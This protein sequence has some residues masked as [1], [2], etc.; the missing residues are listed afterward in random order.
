VRENACSNCKLYGTKCE[1]PD[2]LLIDDLLEPLARSTR[3]LSH[4]KDR[5]SSGLHDSIEVEKREVVNDTPD[6][7]VYHESSK[8]WR[9]FMDPSL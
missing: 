5:P 9:F 7:A 8:G 3:N 6:P 2:S 1:F 4:G